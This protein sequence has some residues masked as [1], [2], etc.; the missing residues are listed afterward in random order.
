MSQSTDMLQLR[1]CAAAYNLAEITCIVAQDKKAMT[2]LHLFTLI[3]LVPHDQLNSPPIGT[4]GHPNTLRQNANDQ[5]TLYLIRITGLKVADMLVLYEHAEHGISINQGSINFS[6]A[7]PYT[8]Q[9]DPPGDH[10][11]LIK[12]KEEKTIGA[13]LPHRRT[14]C[15]VWAKINID[16]TWVKGMS[17]EFFTALSELSQTAMKFDLAAAPEHIGNVYLFASNPVVRFWE[18]SM[19]DLEKQVLVSFYE[20]MG[21][22]VL[23][24]RLILQEIRSDNK[25]FYIEQEITATRQR[26]DLPYFPDRLETRMLDRDGRLIDYSDGVWTNISVILGIQDKLINYSV[27][28]E[29]GPLFFS[30]PKIMCDSKVNVGSYDR[31]IAHYLKDARY[32]RRY[33][34]LEKTN[35]FVFFP[36]EETSIEKANKVVHAILN[37]AHLRCVILDPYFSAKD[38]VYVFH[39]ENVSVPVQIISSGAFLKQTRKPPRTRWQKIRSKIAELVGKK[40]RALTN[41]EELLLALQSYEKLYPVQKIDCR[42]L[43]GYPS[44]LHDRY[45]IVDEDAYLLG[46]SLNEFGNRTTTLIKVPAPAPMIAQALAWWDDCSDLK[47][48]CQSKKSRS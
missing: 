3:E 31:T 20:R 21:N 10:S 38:L 29:D 15:R 18:Y 2:W 7:L 35:D 30:V 25:G 47:T 19:P 43:P 48:Y 6:A 27:V 8:L 14:H 9:A 12:P 40:Q 23:G 11:L 22:T 13:L 1:S 26:I 33:Q 46:S 39:I 34:E 44:P 17:K 42:V 32:Q 41:A 28:T 16:K 4:A 37:R 45:I 5:Y 24:C 36:K